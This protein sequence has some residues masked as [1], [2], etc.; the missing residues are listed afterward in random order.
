[1]K[2]GEFT[3]Q[4]TGVPV[5]QLMVLVGKKASLQGGDGNKAVGQNRDQHMAGEGQ[6][7]IRRRIV[8]AN[9]QRC[10]DADCS[11]GKQAEKEYL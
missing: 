7:H 10:H 2:R 11:Q 8:A 3:N 6:A 4:S 5:F 1:M 9:D